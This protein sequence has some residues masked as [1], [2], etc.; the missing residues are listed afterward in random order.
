MVV[1][2]ERTVSQPK[3]RTYY[4]GQLGVCP[5]GCSTEKLRYV[6]RSGLYDVR[7]EVTARAFA[8]L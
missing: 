8:A 6:R 4:L 5:S 1:P 2:S 7:T 3:K